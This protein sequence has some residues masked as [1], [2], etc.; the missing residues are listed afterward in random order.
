[1]M[2]TRHIC[3]MLLTMLLLAPMG[4]ATDGRQGGGVECET[5]ITIESFQ[6][7]SIS[8]P[9]GRC[10]E[11]DLGTLEGGTVLELDIDASRGDPIDLLLFDANGLQVYLS[12]QDYRSSLSVPVSESNLS[13]ATYLHW[14]TPEFGSRAWTL[15]LDN[16]DHPGVEDDASDG[17]EAIVSGSITPFGTAQGSHPIPALTV[18]HEALR[19]ENGM[20]LT[21]TGLGNLRVDAGTLITLEAWVATGSIDV[22]MQGPN[23]SLAWSG[24][25]TTGLHVSEGSLL[26]VRATEASLSMPSGSRTY[27]VPSSLEGVPISILVD[28]GGRVE[29]GSNDSAEALISLRVHLTPSLSPNIADDRSGRTSLDT[30]ITFDLDASPNRLGQMDASTFIWSFGDGIT[31][32]S[33]DTSVS[34][35]YTSPGTYQVAVQATH[36]LGFI[37]NGTRTVIVEDVRPP[38]L[39]LS[40]TGGDRTDDDVL[41]VDPGAQLTLSAERSSDDDRI[42][43]TTWTLDGVVVGNG[44]TF[45][46][47]QPTVGTRTLGLRLV[48]PSGNPTNATFSLRVV[49]RTAPVLRSESVPITADEGQTIQLTAAAEDAWD[50]PMD[51]T[52]RWD[53]DASNDEDMLVEGATVEVLMDAPGLRRITLTV[54]DQSGNQVTSSYEID[55]KG[56]STEGL[57][58]TLLGSLFGL[59]ALVLI[60]VLLTSRL[61]APGRARALLMQY[62]LS[63]EA[64]DARLA[65][66]RSRGRRSILR[67]WSPQALADIDGLLAGREPTE[68]E[69]AEAERDRLYGQPDPETSVE[70]MA[71]LP[72]ARPEVIVD[73]TAMAELMPTSSAPSPVSPSSSPVGVRSSGVSLPEG[74]DPSHEGEQV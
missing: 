55:V 12:D 52:Y 53:L 32:S 45:Q 69:R 33:T 50:D 2:R 8:I 57:S 36:P 41:L 54:T 59:G 71:G 14:R 31:R 10:V 5:T 20:N 49:D 48:D 66:V 37:G 9:N 67:S 38:T 1:M 40:I 18:F 42:D 74:F 24:T 15:V 16:L 60:G 28:N 58:G 6:A 63:A 17:G 25:S 35:S 19:L 70:S 11:I 44:S 39:E 26:D 21:P 51:L 68:E 61:R 7:S 23:E 56:T 3:G 22:L 29:G 73:A 72:P 62:G 13:D 27:Q 30:P 64:A 34:H 43:R 46:F 4:A 65:E 47:S